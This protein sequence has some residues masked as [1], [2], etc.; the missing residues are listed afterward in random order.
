MGLM[1]VLPGGA[2]APVGQIWALTQNLMLG[3]TQPLHM[4]TGYMDLTSWGDGTRKEEMHGVQEVAVQ[5]KVAPSLQDGRN[6]TKMRDTSKDEA[7]FILVVSH[8][9]THDGDHR[10]AAPWD[11]GGHLTPETGAHFCKC[12]PPGVPRR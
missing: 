1:G 8:F 12:Q 9:K 7:E 4:Y 3:K 10:E 2:W 5:H 11:P 6:G